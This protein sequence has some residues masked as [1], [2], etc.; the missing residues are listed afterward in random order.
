M[1][2]LYEANHQWAN[3]P[4][5]QRF[6]SLEE[7]YR[8][9]SSYY[10]SAVTSQALIDSLRVEAADNNL[11]LVGSTGQHAKLT[12]YSFGQLSAIA[13][14]PPGYLRT[15]A[16]T[17]AAQNINYGLKQASGNGDKLSLLFHKNGSTVARAIT[18]DS[19]DRVWNWEVLRAINDVVTSQGWMV[20]PARPAKA[21]Q[22]GTRKATAAD[23]LP[24]Q[25]DFG[26]AI[27]EGDEIA[28]AGLY[29]SD[30][31]MFVFL[32]KMGETVESGGQLL[33]K[34]VFI[35]NSEVGDCGLKLKFF[36]MDHVC[37]NHIVWNASG[38][39]EVNMRHIKGQNQTRGKTLRVASRRWDRVLRGAP[40]QG[41]LESDIRAAKTKILGTSKEDALDNVYTFAKAKSLSLMTKATIKAA[42]ELAEQSPRYGS[43]NTVWGMVN[44]LTEFSQQGHTDTRTELDC[45][46]GRLMDLIR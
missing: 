33:N 43:P 46:A 44:G 28:P 16:P 34:G 18:T 40:S 21:G 4:E 5:D 27:K 36:I 14:A 7:M 8:A 38:V 17:L 45:Q 31:D 22:A 9:C 42:Y 37:G 11:H 23:V 3:R 24:N 20:P 10:S 6:S 26:L 2:N 15:L 41:T 30:H 19:Y 25:G 39:T 32:V 35:Q 29:A 13:G 1:S 12:H